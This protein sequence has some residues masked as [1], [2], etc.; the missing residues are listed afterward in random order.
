MCAVILWPSFPP[1]A[2]SQNFSWYYVL[3]GFAQSVLN[4]AYDGTSTTKLGRVFNSL[5]DPSLYILHIWLSICT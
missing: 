5:I 3:Q 2:P 4:G 1:Q